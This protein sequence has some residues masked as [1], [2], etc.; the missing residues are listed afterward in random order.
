MKKVRLFL[1]AIGFAVS[2][3][4]AGWTSGTLTSIGIIDSNLGPVCEFVVGGVSY[5]FVVDDVGQQ[6]KVDAL[7]T[8]KQLGSSVGVLWD[9][10][11]TLTY[12][13]DYNSTQN[14]LLAIGLGF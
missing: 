8:A 5:A 1:A 2:L 3:S 14:K 4:T 9:G 7:R 6:A 11:V 12:T 10:S 13:P